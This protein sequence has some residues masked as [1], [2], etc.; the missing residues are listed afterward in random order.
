MGVCWEDTSE[1]WLRV[2]DWAPVRQHGG[3]LGRVWKGE[4]FPQGLGVRI[5]EGSPDSIC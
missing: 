3:M 2:G 4:A 1:V 5:V